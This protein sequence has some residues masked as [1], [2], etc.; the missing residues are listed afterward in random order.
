MEAT[1]D[2]PTL[3][4]G[5]SKVATQESKSVSLKVTKANTRN[6]IDHDNTIALS[7]KSVEHEKTMDCSE[8]AEGQETLVLPKP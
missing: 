2:A 3:T 6:L 8:K 1:Q 7:E 4:G 5:V